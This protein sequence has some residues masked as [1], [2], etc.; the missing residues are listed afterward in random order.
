MGRAYLLERAQ[1]VPY[2]RAEVFAFF[3]HAQNL[4]QITPSF[5]RF[6]ILTPGP[7]SMRP[8]ALIDYRLQLF[9]VPVWWRTRIE[10]FEPP[11]RFVDVQLGGP[12]RRWRHTH[13]FEDTPGGTVVHDRVEYELPLGPL[14]ALARALFVRPALKRIFDHRRKRIAELL[15]RRARRPKGRSPAHRP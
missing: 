14:G 6:R 15:A 1:F 2:P 5:L 9:G 4:E 8:G 12:Y 3:A 13:K 10:V 7:I 11:V